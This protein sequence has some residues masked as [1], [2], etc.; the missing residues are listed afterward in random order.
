LTPLL[1]NQ[2]TFKTFILSEKNSLDVIDSLH[3]RHEFNQWYHA[4]LVYENGTMHNYINQVHESFGNVTY[5]PIENG[6]I[7]I[8]ARQDPRSWLKGTIRFIKFTKRA[9]TPLEFTGIPTTNMELEKTLPVTG[10]LYQNYPNPFNPV[11]KIKFALPQT[12]ITKLTIYD[13]LGREVNTLINQ[14]LSAGY[15]EV[16]LNAGNIPSGIYFYRIDAGRFVSVK[17]CIIK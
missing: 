3:Y 15:H 4:A 11:T 14:E 9:L 5:I 13:L 1:N 10:Q 6:Q 16:E 12:S 7:S 2:W 17:K 8:G